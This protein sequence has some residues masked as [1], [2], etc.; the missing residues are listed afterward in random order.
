M[1]YLLLMYVWIEDQFE[2]IIMC[3]CD[4]RTSY[5]LKV[6]TKSHGTILI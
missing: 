1:Y 6:L 3:Q 2:I 4:L 5:K